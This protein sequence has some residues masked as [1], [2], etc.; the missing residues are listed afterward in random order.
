[1]K[2]E[3][4]KSKTCLECAVVQ[5]LDNFRIKKN[6]HGNYY[7]MGVCKCCT[8]KT[9][10]KDKKERYN[11]SR[12]SRTKM[13]QTIAKYRKT[14]PGK[15]IT[16]KLS[17][18]SD[19]KQRERLTDNYLLKIIVTNTQLTRKDILDCKGLLQAKRNIIKLKRLTRQ[20]CLKQKK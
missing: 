11:T 12:V 4:R 3:N 10:A 6:R 13:L 15:L 7:V 20:P 17:R 8:R 2:L 19:S 1:M 16:N 5:P 14:K 9:D 18:L